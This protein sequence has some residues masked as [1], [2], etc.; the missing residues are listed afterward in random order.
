MKDSVDYTATATGT[1]YFALGGKGA[2]VAS[3]SQINVRYDDINITK[4]TTTGIKS[5]VASNGSVYPN[6][7]NGVLNIHTTAA[8]ASVE[9]YNA[10][11]QNVMS[12]SLTNG[13]NTIDMNGLSSGVYTVRLIQ[14]GAS[15]ITKVIKN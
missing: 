5:N 11:G 3:T 12:K 13:T 9:F 7:T 8:N 1:R 4:V 14:D 6:P 15:T 10:M 2:V